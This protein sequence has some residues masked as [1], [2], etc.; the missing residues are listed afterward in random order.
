[1]CI[2]IYIVEIDLIAGKILTQEPN[3]VNKANFNLQGAN[4]AELKLARG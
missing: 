1:M 2:K 4:L 3:L